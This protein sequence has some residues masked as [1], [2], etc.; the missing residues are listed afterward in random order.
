MQQIIK[1]TVTPNDTTLTQVV[2]PEIQIL[3]L[4]Q[5]THLK[6]WNYSTFFFPNIPCYV[7]LIMVSPQI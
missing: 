5:S 2:A 4:N 7:S 6:F 1:N 3:H